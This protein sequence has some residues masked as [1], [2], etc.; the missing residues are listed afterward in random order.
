MALLEMAAA[1]DS[2]NT[3]AEGL[4]AASVEVVTVVQTLRVVKMPWNAVRH[5]REP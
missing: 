2:S 4:M 1:R 3:V 5:I